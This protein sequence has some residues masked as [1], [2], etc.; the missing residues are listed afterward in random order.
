MVVRTQRINPELSSAA[1]F[2][3]VAIFLVDLSLPLGVAGGVPYV[4]LVL[5]GWWFHKRSYI[6]VLAAVS[7][8]LTAAAYFFSPEGGIAWMVLT[9][10]ALAFFAIWVTAVL[11]YTAKRAEEILRASEEHCRRIYENTPVMLHSVGR[12]GRLLSV[13]D[14]WLTVLGYGRGEVIGEMVV[15]FMTEESAKYVIE[16]A[17]P[18]FIKTGRTTDL[19]LQ[20][21]KKNG[22]V[23]DILVSAVVER[24][25][26][27]KFVRSLTVLTDVTERKRAEEAL[28][29]AHDELES[30]VEERTRELTGEVAE[31]GRVEEELRLRNREL[32]TL[33]KISEIS[34]QPHTL[35][36]AF[37]SIVDVISKA[38]KFPDVSIE[39]YDRKF[40]GA[41]HSRTKGVP[42]PSN[43]DSRRVPM[44]DTFCHAIVRNRG[45]MGK[46]PATNGSGRARKL[47]RHKMETIIPVPMIMGETVVGVLT[48]AH[49]EKIDLKGRLPKWAA[50]LANYL[51]TL[52]D[53]MRAEEVLHKRVDLYR[54]LSKRI[55]TAGATSLHDHEL[56]ELLLLLT[57]PRDDAAALTERLMSGLG[58]FAET[59]NA[60]PRA[61]KEIHGGDEAIVAF[62]AVREAA[63]R[64]AREDLTKRPIFDSWDKLITYCRI[65]MAHE[66]TEHFRVLYL[67]RSNI[68]IA[69]EVGQK[70]TVDQTPF[71]PREVVKR[72]L[73]LS[74]TALVLVHNHPSGDPTPSGDDIEVTKD[75]MEAVESLGIVLHDHL[76]I[77]KSTHYSFRNMGL[78]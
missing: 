29:K 25:E 53:R 20:F 57:A 61:I 13:S 39:L 67:N 19:P 6:F 15:T 70:G 43:G 32:L 9:N 65:G 52:T 31:R 64:L 14:H 5:T 74:A 60:E 68:L 49:P 22:E 35:A 47:K 50:T 51:A 44:E 18:E 11:L 33:H 26:G 27:G 12:D 40:N 21:V 23:V 37:Q 45:P 41:A 66:K 63:I 42:V 17:H 62:A 4:A 75:V 73:E 56:M 2:L 76:I 28:R 69:D 78:M 38:T 55:E 77:S 46:V 10:R 54:E 16:S 59:I 48:L 72:A 30:R 24:D 3:A 34:L 36:E 1:A 7:S 8:V 71:Y 58:S